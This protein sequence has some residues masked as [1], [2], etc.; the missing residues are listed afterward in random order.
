MP[1]SNQSIH[2]GL[3]WFLTVTTFMSGGLGFL[4]KIDGFYNPDAYLVYNSQGQLLPGDGTTPFEICA[5]FVIAIAYV[6]PLVGIMYAKWQ[7]SAAAKQAAAIFP[8]VYHASM[9]PGVLWVFPHSLD[10]IKA[11][12]GAA[13]S[14]HAVYAGLFYMFVRT[15]EDDAPPP[16]NKRNL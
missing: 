12:L 3:Y 5:T 15:A 8:L 13:A 11:P 16:P 10:P 7:G 1:I 6:A 14:M 9:I 4:F 2:N